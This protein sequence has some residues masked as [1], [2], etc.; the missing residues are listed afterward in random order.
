MWSGQAAGS[1]P[2]W[3]L[4]RAGASRRSSNMLIIELPTPWLAK[5]TRT[6]KRSV[7]Y[8][9]S[10][11]MVKLSTIYLGLRTGSA[12]DAGTDSRGAVV[13]N[14]KQFTFL[15]DTFQQDLEPNFANLYGISGGDGIEV[16]LEDLTDYSVLLLILG[17]DKWLPDTVVV[18]GHRL[19]DDAAIPLAI[20]TDNERWLST[21]WDEGSAVLPIRLVGQGSG[22][23]VLNRSLLLIETSAEQDNDGTED[24]INVDVFTK[25]GARR[26]H[27]Q[28]LGQSGEHPLGGF[29][30]PRALQPGDVDMDFVPVEIPF[31]KNEIARI[32]LSTSGDDAWLPSRL[33]LFGLDT[34]FG[35]PEALVPLVS[36]FTWPFGRLSVDSTEGQAS[37]NLP[38]A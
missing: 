7:D 13:V 17:D 1:N 15:E 22:D 35:R 29:S 33:F 28:V 38:L 34:E 23:T 19:S 26:V 21:D 3:H 20:E 31:T 14:G 9:R 36:I 18:W 10:Q 24:T 27:H 37:V 2:T 16:T 30:A 4:P 6:A 25:E 5:L 12:E 32:T 8:V 11:H